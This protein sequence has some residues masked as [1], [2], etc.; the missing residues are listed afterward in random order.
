M[1]EALE[2]CFNVA[3]HGEITSAFGVVPFESE[4]TVEFGLPVG[5]DCVLLAED[6]CQMLGMFAANIFDC[7]VVDNKAKR[8]GFGLVSEKTMCVCILVV[9]VGG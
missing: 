4:A 7:K 1:L 9:A 3:R 6:G 5:G 8:D 2:S